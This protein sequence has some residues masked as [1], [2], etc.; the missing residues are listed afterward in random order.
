MP[1]IHRQGVYEVIM[2][3]DM[4]NSIMRDLPEPD[5]AR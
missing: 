5:N 3:Y 2:A 4:Y 1:A